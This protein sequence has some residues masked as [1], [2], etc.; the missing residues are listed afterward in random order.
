MNTTSGSPAVRVKASTRLPR[1]PSALLCQ[2]LPYCRNCNSQ[3]FS[4]LRCA[5]SLAVTFVQKRFRGPIVHHCRHFLL[6]PGYRLGFQSLTT[7]LQPTALWV[8]L[9][10]T[11]FV[12]FILIPS[13]LLVT[14]THT[15]GSTFTKPRLPL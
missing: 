9:D 14:V 3:V 13:S 7:I 2:G 4:P 5:F 1:C 8:S 15:A 6:K 12:H 10:V 11:T